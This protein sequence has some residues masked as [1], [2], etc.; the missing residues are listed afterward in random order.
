MPTNITLQMADKSTKKTVG[1]AENVP[2]RLDGHVIPTDFVILDMTED[3]KLSIILGRSFLNTAGAAL[4]CSEGN[5]RRINSEILSE[6][7]RSKG[8]VCSPT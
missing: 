2:L 8:E 5:L 6:E 4:D 3:E 7:A 1:V